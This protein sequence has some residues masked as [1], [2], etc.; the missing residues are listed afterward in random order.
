MYHQ[1]F[2][3]IKQTTVKFS[4]LESV[5]DTSNN[6]P[7]KQIFDTVYESTDTALLF[8]LLS[9]INYLP[10]I[11]NKLGLISESSVSLNGSSHSFF[12]RRTRKGYHGN[13]TNSN[14]NKSTN[15]SN[16]TR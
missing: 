14:F 7:E 5:L 9:K 3:G 8:H 16:I 1:D 15:T 13:K 4:I 6:S 2:F 10:H 12:W 11:T